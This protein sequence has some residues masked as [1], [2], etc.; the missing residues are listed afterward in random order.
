VRLKDLTN[1][2]KQE[3]KLSYSSYKDCKEKKIEELNFKEEK[4]KDKLISNLEIKTKLD[5]NNHLCSQLFSLYC[6]NNNRINQKKSTMKCMFR[7]TLKKINIQSKH[8]FLISYLKA[9]LIYTYWHK[10]TVMIENVMYV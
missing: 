8:R 4:N 6:L 1:R 3:K 2:N 9:E 7:R 10:K 5:Y